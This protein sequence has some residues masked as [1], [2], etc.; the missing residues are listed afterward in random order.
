MKRFI[1]SAMV[2]V[3]L[4]VSI[5]G[6]FPVWERDGR[7]PGHDRGRGHDRGHDHDRGPDQGRGGGH[8]QN[9]GRQ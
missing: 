3:M 2:F 7:G 4:I 5:S 6:C 1:M 9:G 8:D